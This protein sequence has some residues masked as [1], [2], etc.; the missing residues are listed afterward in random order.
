MLQLSIFV[1]LLS[2]IY[3]LS[4]FTFRLWGNHEEPGNADPVITGHMTV[5]EYGRCNR[6]PMPVVVKVFGISPYS[7]TSR[8][9]GSFGYDEREVIRRT[10]VELAAYRE[11]HSKNPTRYTLHFI[12]GLLVMSVV[13]CLFRTSGITPA[14]RK[15]LYLLSLLVFGLGFN[16][17]PSPMGPVKDTLSLVGNIPELIH[18]R[19][20][21][22]LTY[23]VTGVIAH[24]FLCGWVCQLGVL[25]DLIF[26]LNRDGADRMG[27]ARQYRIP[28]AWS[29]TIRII[30]FIATVA[31]SLLWALNVIDSINPF[32]I[33]GGIALWWPGW[34]FAGGIMVMSLFVYRPWCH[35]FCPFGLLGWLFEKA[36]IFRIRV[37]PNTCTSCEACAE[38][39]PTHAMSAILHKQPTRPDCFSCGTCMNACPNGSVTFGYHRVR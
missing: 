7:D 28:F 12:L 21:A 11:E 26:R 6:L 5:S 14:A 4:G 13:F 2:G 35:L 38:E 39:C 27:I 24:K 18:P 3:L 23:L 10:T 32:A 29:N 9:V 31:S 25:Q 36:T 15:S 33:F 34:V 37:N 20:F 22:I 16:A 19:L 30:F 8:Q 1:L 17:S